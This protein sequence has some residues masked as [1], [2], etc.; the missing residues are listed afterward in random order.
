MVFANLQGRV[1]PVNEKTV[2]K[3][4]RG[5]KQIKARWF[6]REWVLR[7]EKRKKRIVNGADRFIVGSPAL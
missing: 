3:S 2:A 4:T 5:T 1:V 7:E 6:L